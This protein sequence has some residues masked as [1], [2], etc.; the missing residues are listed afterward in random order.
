MSFARLDAT[1][2]KERLKSSEL[3]RGINVV[4]NLGLNLQVPSKGNLFCK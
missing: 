2:G 3:F 4:D 1:S